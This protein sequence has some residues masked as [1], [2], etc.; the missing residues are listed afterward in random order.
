MLK[1]QG[2]LKERT[3]QALEL[4]F[5][6]V[7]EAR[8]QQSELYPTEISSNGQDTAAMARSQNSFSGSAEQSYM[9]PL[10]QPRTG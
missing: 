7:A 3:R 2:L 5:D 9:L 10:Q 1:V 6:Y 8:N 4:L